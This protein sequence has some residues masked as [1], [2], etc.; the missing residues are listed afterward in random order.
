MSSVAALLRCLILAVFAAGAGLSATASPT[1]Q[2]AAAALHPCHETAAG[3]TTP[4]PPEQIC[5]QHCLGVSL[6]VVPV[7]ATAPVGRSVPV[8]VAVLDE[9]AASLWPTPEGHPPRI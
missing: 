2:V 4:M 6:P 5:R 1:A 9:D 8:E 7:A 3:G